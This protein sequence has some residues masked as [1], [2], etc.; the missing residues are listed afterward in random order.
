[1]RTM[2]QNDRELLSIV[3]EYDSVIG[4]QPR[5]KVH[6]EDLRHRAVHIL[7]FNAQQQ[8]FLQKRSLNKDINPGLWD[9]SAAGHV[10]AG[11][12][13]DICAI[14]ELAEELGIRGQVLQLMFKLDA[15]VA[16]GMEFIQVFRCCYNGEMTLAADEIEDGEWNGIEK[17]NERI[18]N[19][20]PTLTMAFKLIWST[21][22]NAS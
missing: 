18:A 8:L 17:V 2:K 20:D 7:V 13:Y 5:A 14:R 11:E 9:S 21:Y 1:M 3:D 16:T 15:C 6:A 12:S 4:A 22:Q 10:D 19:D